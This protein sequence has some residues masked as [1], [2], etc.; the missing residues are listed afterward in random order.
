MMELTLSTLRA[1]CQ[2]FYIDQMREA[3]LKIT[4]FA[5][6]TTISQLHE[7]LRTKTLTK[8]RR[9]LRTKIQLA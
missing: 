4:P 1:N 2:I 9:Q 5:D 6:E 7:E 8:V 3:I